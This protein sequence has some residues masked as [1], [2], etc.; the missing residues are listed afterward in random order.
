MIAVVTI[1][2]ALPLGYFVRNTVAAYL[3]YVAAFAYA[4]SF[5]NVYLLMDWYN[6]NSAAYPDEGFPI[7]YLAVTLAVYLTGFALVT[8]GRRLRRRRALVQQ[9]G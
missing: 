8:A 1:L 7:S 9:A 2:C 5:Q 4:F 6:G 3:G